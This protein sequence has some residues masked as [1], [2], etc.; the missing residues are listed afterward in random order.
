VLWFTKDLVQDP[1]NRQQMLDAFRLAD[2]RT[3]R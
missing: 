3:L 1:Q 2:Y